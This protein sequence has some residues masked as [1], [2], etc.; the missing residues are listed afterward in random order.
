MTFQPVIPLPG[1][2]GWNFLQSTYDRQFETFSNSFQIK[3]DMEYMKE[4]LNSRPAIEDFL[5]DP[6]LR[7]VTLTAFGLNGEEWKIGFHRKVLEEQQDPE[8][9]FLQRLNNPQYTRFAE[10]LSPI[11]GELVL[12]SDQVDQIAA[13]YAAESFE[14]AVGEQNN[15]MRLSLNYQAEIG[16]IITEGA[17]DETI[18]FRMLGDIPMRSVLETALSIPSDVAQ[19]DLDRQADIFTDRLRSQL[20]ISS[21]QELKDPEMVDKMIA[22]YQAIDGINQ[23]SATL[24]SASTALTLLQNAAGFGAVAS[25][26]LFL[27]GF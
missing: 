23:Q 1:L 14:L 17:S 10:A 6:R 4:K 5:S 12:S 15:S 24:S 16:E 7:R 3:D 21:L 19:L 9:T 18:I 2:G 26:N 11:D 22:R 25:Q 8:S 27:S 20:N 13:R